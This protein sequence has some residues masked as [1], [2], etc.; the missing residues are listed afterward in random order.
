MGKY[1]PCLSPEVW[2]ID[3]PQKTETEFPEFS[4]GIAA[5]KEQGIYIGRVPGTT[6]A[7]PSRERELRK[8]GLTDG[9]VA[10]ARGVSRRTVQLTQD[11]F[12]G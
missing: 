1:A 7:T 9:E 6:K 8:T 12:V 3:V 4:R 5:E 11:R 2:P 10:K